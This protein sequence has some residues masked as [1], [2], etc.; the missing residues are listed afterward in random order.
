[1]KVDMPTELHFWIVDAV[2]ILSNSF[3]SPGTSTDKHFGFLCWAEWLLE[4]F[5][6]W[7]WTDP[8]FGEP[9]TAQID[10]WLVLV[11]IAHQPFYAIDPKS[12]FIHINSSISNNSVYYKNS[13]FVYTQLNVKNSF[14]SNNSV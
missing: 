6:V 9:G 12:I 5:S 10:G 8:I 14:I 2:H 13:F 7:L 3:L 1:M 4:N 11:F